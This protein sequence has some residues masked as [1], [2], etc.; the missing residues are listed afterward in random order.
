MKQDSV[1][2][3]LC[4]DAASKHATQAYFDCLRAEIERHRIPVTVISPG[5]IRTNLSVNAV[6]GDGSK[7]GGEVNFE[8]VVKVWLHLETGIFQLTC[9]WIGVMDFLLSASIA[10][11]QLL[12]LSKKRKDWWLQK[13]VWIYGCHRWHC[14]DPHRVRSKN[15]PAFT[16]L[17]PPCYLKTWRGCRRTS[18]KKIKNK[19]VKKYNIHFKHFSVL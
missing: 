6:T 19:K 3:T 17:V 9:V 18:M 1:L 7:Y 8:L 2:Y 11:K 12:W 16:A 10:S 5:Y 4:S 13:Q 14:L 15:T